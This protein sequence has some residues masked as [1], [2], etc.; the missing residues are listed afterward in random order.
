MYCC[1]QGI[2]CCVRPQPLLN[3]DIKIKD[4]CQKPKGPFPA[5]TAADSEPQPK[6]EVS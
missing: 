2:H 6:I 5:E 3:N 1:R 4:N